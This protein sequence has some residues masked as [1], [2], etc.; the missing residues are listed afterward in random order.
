MSTTISSTPTTTTTSASD[1]SL[2]TAETDG[3]DMQKGASYFFG[4]LVTFV[5]LLLLFVVCGL[6]SRRRFIAR[7]RAMLDMGVTDPWL[8][9]YRAADDVGRVEP[10]L[11]EPHLEKGG[12]MWC[13]MMPLSTTIRRKGDDEEHGILIPVVPVIPVVT[14]SRSL[15]FLPIASW[16]PSRSGSINNGSTTTT[17][18]EKP[19][20]DLTNETK[21]PDPLEIQVVVMIAMPYDSE[22]GEPEYQFGVTREAW[23]GGEMPSG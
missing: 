19:S 13:T 18:T 23:K 7:R 9:G 5:V 15:S 8:M 16:F 10:I 11:L 3:A 14:P 2:P 4:F 20:N 21:P 17:T 6:A 22:D 1:S 12:E